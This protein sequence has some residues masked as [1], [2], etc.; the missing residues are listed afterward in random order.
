MMGFLFSYLICLGA[1]FLI[2]KNYSQKMAKENLT[3]IATRSFYFLL[4][5]FVLDTLIIIGALD[6]LILLLNNFSWANISGGLD[7][8]Y[9]CMLIGLINF[10]IP[11]DMSQ[12]TW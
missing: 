9:N 8:Y 7:W 2:Q 11:V 10:N 12:N 5:L 6:G 4:I 1:A 3:Y